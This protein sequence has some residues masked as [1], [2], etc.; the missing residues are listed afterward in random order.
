M[1]KPPQNE[2]SIYFTSVGD[3]NH[4][5]VRTGGSR[6]PL[7]TA[8]KKS[9]RKMSVGAFERSVTQPGRYMQLAKDAAIRRRNKLVARQGEHIEKEHLYDCVLHSKLEKNK[10]HD[11][12]RKLKSEL[13][14]AR[15]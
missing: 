3:E 11:E 7:S 2:S 13:N 6:P 14:Q 4:L 1:L 8:N 10:A 15:Q 5:N 12:L 9:K